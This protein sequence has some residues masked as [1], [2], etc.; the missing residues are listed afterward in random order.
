M[1]MMEDMDLLQEY[2][3]RGSEPAFATLVERHINLV[4]G[5]AMRHVANPHQAEEITQ[6]VFIIL[7]RKAASLR[8][9]TI[10]AGWLFQ[11]VRLTAANFR[12]TEIRRALREQEAYMQS[13]LHEKD[14]DSVWQQIAPMLDA[15]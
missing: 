10:L 14:T 1:Q 15:A 11:T 12:R 5:A 2:A 3:T 6:A 9:G 13:T 4:Y 8:Q 7:A